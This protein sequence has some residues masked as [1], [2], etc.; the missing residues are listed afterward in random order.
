MTDTAIA[1][2]LAHE[3]GMKFRA[4]PDHPDRSAIFCAK[5]GWPGQEFDHVT[6]QYLREPYGCHWCN[7]QE[8]GR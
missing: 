8:T 3:H 5:C 1:L 6:S 4:D 2:R 7:E